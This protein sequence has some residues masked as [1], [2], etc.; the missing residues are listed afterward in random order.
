MIHGGTCEHGID[1]ERYM[2]LFMPPKKRDILN[3]H[4]LNVGYAQTNEGMRFYA[5]GFEIRSLAV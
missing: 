4:W 2:F 3:L 1:R 5:T